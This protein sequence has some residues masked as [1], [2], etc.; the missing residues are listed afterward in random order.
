MEYKT[1]RGLKSHTSR[2]HPKLKL[3]CKVKDCD[4]G[5]NSQVNIDLHNEH[6]HERDTC[7]TSD[8][9]ITH[10]NAQKEGTM[11]ENQKRTEITHQGNKRT[12]PKAK[13]ERFKRWGG[14]SQRKH[15]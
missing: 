2:E 10:R 3:K 15:L 8:N 5:T 13:R 9:E 14:R 1:M 7:S 12:H 11:N 6:T 4:Y